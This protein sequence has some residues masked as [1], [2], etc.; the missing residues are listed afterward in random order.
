MNLNP[1]P[2]IACGI[3][4]KYDF[5]PK[6]L[7]QKGY[8][9]WALGKVSPTSR[10]PVHPAIT[11]LPL[12]PRPAVPIAHVDS[13]LVMVRLTPD[14]G[15]NYWGT[16]YWGHSVSGSSKRCVTCWVDWG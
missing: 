7:K 5:M 8:E 6:M 9:T 14:T 16:N 10:W 13:F 15:T 3:N 2:G 1:T 12:G 11:I 4:L